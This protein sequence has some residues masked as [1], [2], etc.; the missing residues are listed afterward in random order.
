MFIIYRSNAIK[1]LA[2][3][4]KKGGNIL[5]LVLC[6]YDNSLRALGETYDKGKR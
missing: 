6:K 5:K 3:L 2:F 1:V 4:C